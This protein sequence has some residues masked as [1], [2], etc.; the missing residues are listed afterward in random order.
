MT[1]ATGP[2]T[3]D[4]IRLKRDGGT[5][6]GDEV[7]WLIDAYTRGDIADEQMSAL[8]MAVFFRGLAPAELREWTAAMIASGER[9]ELSGGGRPTV[10]KHST[11]GVGDKVSLI[12]APLVASCGA[13]VPQLS[14]RGLGHTGGTLD[15]LESI[16]G[17]RTQ[18]SPDEI[19]AQVKTVG[20]CVCAQT[21]RLVPADQKLY[22]LRDATATVESLPLIAASIMSKKIAGGSRAV[23]LDVKVGGG[24]FMKTRDDA[25]ALAA[26]MVRIGAA[27]GQRVVAV[28]SDMNVPLGRS[29]GN[30]LEIDEVSRLLRSVPGVD[31]DLIGIVR[32]LSAAGFL[33][34]GR[35]ASLAEGEAL[36]D[37]QVASGAAF[38]KFCEIV[39]AQGG[40]PA[41]LR[42]PDKPPVARVLVPVSADRSGFIA[43]IDALAV[44]LAAM[45][46]GAGRATKE[47]SIDPT[48][49]VV[50]SVT[51]G[52]PV[53]AGDPL[54]T[55]Y[56][57]AEDTAAADQVR[58]AVTIS[59]AP[60]AGTPLIHE[61]LGL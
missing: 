44:G 58:Q 23:V 5:L 10:D 9:L 41:Y 6:S 20:A 61:T 25:R 26:L 15:K 32:F 53:A 59:D 22:A 12:L 42:H 51:L 39:A 46:L 4:L 2:A 11:G 1:D 28:L 55:L 48:A 17:L 16:P 47:D 57:S 36:A 19:L 45:R 60:P 7:R 27:H 24:A 30:R 31:A 40:D 34:A 37:R 29:V 18:L 21:P 43:R 38:D 50:L 52:Q 56:A 8:L 49:G 14:G 13:A 54:A 33:V 3:V 35:V